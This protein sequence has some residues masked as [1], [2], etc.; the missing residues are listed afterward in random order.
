MLFILIQSSQSDSFYRDV[1]VPLVRK[2]IFSLRPS[3]VS[4]PFSLFERSPHTSKKFAHNF[5][6]FS[7][8]PM[9][10]VVKM[11]LVLLL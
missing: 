7:F 10:L 8:R 5:D 11:Y 6:F 4:V 2:L 9:E 3:T 1:R